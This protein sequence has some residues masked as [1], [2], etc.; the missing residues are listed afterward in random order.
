MSI[1][2]VGT[3]QLIGQLYAVEAGS[4]LEA[5][6][7]L[8]KELESDLIDRP[9]SFSTIFE[10]E[11]VV[12]INESSIP[13]I[14]E[15]LYANQAFPIENMDNV[16]PEDLPYFV[17]F[18]EETGGVEECRAD[19]TG[20]SFSQPYYSEGHPDADVIM[21]AIAESLLNPPIHMRATAYSAIR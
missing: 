14:Q 12:E 18:G 7:I 19:A 13:E 5:R 20:P 16:E 9:I 17:V 8:E 10:E 6:I 21:A 3:Q 2:V 15:V 1:Y 11:I 4:A